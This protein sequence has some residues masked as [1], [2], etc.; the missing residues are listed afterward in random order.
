MADSENVPDEAAGGTPPLKFSPSD[1][2]HLKAA[3]GWIELG[4][5]DVAN[6]ELENITPEL[7]AHP[8]VLK[9]RFGV[10]LAA[11]HFESAIAA[12]DALLKCQPEQPEGWIDRSIV[13]HEMD[14]T[15]EAQ[16]KL[17]PAAEKFPDDWR[18]Q[19]NLARYACQ[20]GEI[21]EARAFLARAI[22]L[23][24]ADKVKLMAL[25]DRD[26]SPLFKTGEQE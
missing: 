25:D 24:D 26:L 21:E 23:G 8:D 1:L 17:R 6:D 7:R 18:I 14:R 10:Y 2:H 19:Y 20:L 12:A 5:W 16:E 13:L 4:A 3:Q 15:A 11:K 9:L 22:E